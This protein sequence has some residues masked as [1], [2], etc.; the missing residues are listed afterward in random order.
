MAKENSIKKQLFVEREKYTKEGK[1]FFS[2]FVR[3]LIRGKEVK[4]R[5][6]PSDMGGYDILD[7]VFLTD[8]KAE[9]IIT[10]SEMTGEDGRIVKFTSYECRNID[11]ETGVVYSCKLKP[12]RASDKAILEMLNQ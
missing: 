6:S 2:Y 4:A 1:D 8:E 3:G 7:I 10:P 5:M 9:L 12:Q 11:A